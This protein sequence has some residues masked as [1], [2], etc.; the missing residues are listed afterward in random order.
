VK[1]RAFVEVGIFGKG[2]KRGLIIDVAG[3]ASVK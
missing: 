2:F 3:N 1:G